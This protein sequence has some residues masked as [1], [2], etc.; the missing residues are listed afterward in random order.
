VREQSPG[1]GLYDSRVEVL[2]G[3]MPSARIGNSKK[4]GFFSSISHSVDSPGPGNYDGNYHIKSPSSIGVKF[5]KAD[6]KPK[7]ADTPGPGSYRL[8]AKFN[9]L[10]SYALPNRPESSR[11]V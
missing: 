5:N 1:P 3:K 11:Y 6:P 9:D 4:D 7:T 10:P 8:P 2:K